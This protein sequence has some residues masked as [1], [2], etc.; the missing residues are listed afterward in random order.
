MEEA[1]QRSGWALACAL[2]AVVVLVATWHTY[3]VVIA[4]HVVPGWTVTTGLLVAAAGL[5][6]A[7]R[8]L[9][10]GLSLAHPVSA[11]RL[12]G[13]GAGDVLPRRWRR[14]GLRAARGAGLARHVSGYVTDDADDDGGRPVSAGGYALTWDGGHGTLQVFDTP[15]NP[16][17]PATHSV[18][19]G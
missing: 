17:D 14:R 7:A 9:G 6:P 12:P 3:L 16:V 18:V 19:C 11:D 10:G 4:G 8:V 5:L 13:P 1:Q 2:A 15:G